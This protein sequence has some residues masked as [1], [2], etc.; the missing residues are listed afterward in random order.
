MADR[1]NGFTINSLV[2]LKDEGLPPCKWLTG[3]IVTCHPGGDN[4]ARVVTVKTA[5]GTFQRSV[6]KFVSSRRRQHGTG[7]N[8]QDST[9]NLPAI[10]QQI[11]PTA[12]ARQR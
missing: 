1:E 8:S 7:S 11:V 10:C 4:M 6:S 3:R 2:L 9:W 5:H 12:I